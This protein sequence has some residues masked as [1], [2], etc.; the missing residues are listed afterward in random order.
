LVDRPGPNP[1]EQFGFTNSS[2]T[3]ANYVPVFDPKDYTRCAT[4][5]STD[6]CA[7]IRDNISA[8]ASSGYKSP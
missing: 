4:P 2:L 3:F 6:I 8:W 1:F 7:A 5:T